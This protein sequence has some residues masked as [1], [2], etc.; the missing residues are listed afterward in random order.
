METFKEG[1]FKSLDPVISDILD[2][3]LNDKEISSQEAIELF[4]TKN[5]DFTAVELA[6]D[7]LRRKSVGDIVTF[8]FNRNINFTNICH[9]GCKFCAFSRKIGEEGTYLLTPEEIASKAREAWKMGATEVCIQ[10]GLHPKV[11]AY[12]YEKILRA[13]KKE[14]PIHIHGFSP[15][16]IVYGG[17][18]SNLTVI[19]TLKMLK[20]AG[21][22]SMPGTAAE[23][24]D[25][26]IRSEICPKKIKTAEW[27]NIIKTAHNI[28]IP[29]T[30]TIMHGHIE[31]IEHRVKHLAIIR[32]IQKETK[33]FTEFVPLSFM[34]WNAPT[35]LNGKAKPGATGIEDMKMYSISRIMLNR[36]I[37]NIQVSWVKLGVKMAQLALNAGANDFGGTLIEEN[38]SKAAGAVTPQYMRIEEIVRQIK[39]LGRIPAQRTT[40]Y[41]IM[42]YY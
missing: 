29:T 22:D 42:K 25:D 37:R 10:G 31:D 21:L 2:R 41:E 13:I 33:G 23:I 6:A 36:N 5:T 4:K 9:I 40:T 17:S 35:Y 18:K 26:E 30:S 28:G 32:D 7:W 19:E 15:M 11:N 20:E 38:I 27:I 1:F 8:V 39:D 14:T 16:E 12:Y 24:L 34:H 3:A